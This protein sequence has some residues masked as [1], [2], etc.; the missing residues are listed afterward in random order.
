[1][2]ILDLFSKK[3]EQIQNSMRK[4]FSMK[5]KFCLNFIKGL[6]LFC[7]VFFSFMPT[8]NAANLILFKNPN[9]GASALAPNNWIMPEQLIKDSYATT[10][11]RVF[12][13]DA[14]MHLECII[15]NDYYPIKSL[16]ELSQ[17]Q[18]ND[19]TSNMIYG[20]LS[21]FK[22]SK[23]I[24]FDKHTN[25]NGI[26]SFVYVFNINQDNEDFRLYIQSFIY[27]HHLYSIKFINR[28]IGILS[29]EELS[30]I[31]CSVRF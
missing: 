17:N 14:K 12:S 10:L 21:M 20:H 24:Y 2:I 28:A 22:E 30:K 23:L 9:S 31:V 15:Y 13:P 8:V 4:I 7:L 26:P 25:F 27:N 19:M 1:M 11:L 29:E 3:S 5:L 16:S 18:I 6:L